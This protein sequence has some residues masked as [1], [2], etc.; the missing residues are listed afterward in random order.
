MRVLLILPC[1]VVKLTARL[2]GGA[3]KLTRRLVKFSSSPGDPPSTTPQGPAPIRGEGV[4][5][6]VCSGEWGCI[7]VVGDSLGDIDRGWNP[8]DSNAGL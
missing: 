1:Y 7:N 5:V 3:C 6:G 8:G 4:A 2:G